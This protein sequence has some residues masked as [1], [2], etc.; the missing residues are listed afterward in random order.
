MLYLLILGYTRI[1]KCFIW[2]VSQSKWL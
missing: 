1:W 2:R